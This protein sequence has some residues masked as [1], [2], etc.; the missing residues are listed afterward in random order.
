[1]NVVD[2]KTKDII[3]EDYHKVKGYNLIL[4]DIDDL[5]ITIK[6]ISQNRTDTYC[7]LEVNFKDN[8][9]INEYS[10]KYACRDK[11]DEVILKDLKEIIFDNTIVLA[12]SVWVTL[13]EIVYDCISKCESRYG[14][15]VKD[16]TQ[17]NCD[18]FIEM[19]SE[20]FK[21]DKIITIYVEHEDKNNIQGLLENK[22]FK[23]V[24]KYDKGNKVSLLLGE[25]EDKISKATKVIDSLVS[26][27][28]S[29]ISARFTKGECMLTIE[30]PNDL[31]E[32]W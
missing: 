4:K 21:E 9:Y 11:L 3:S 5:Y 28:D 7:K 18:A 30:A 20:T 26:Y 16:Y 23:L 1:M 17:H 27:T 24:K 31:N 15:P 2:I 25:N 13:D 14:K 6:F 32:D 10:M 8:K 12:G 22:E 29:T 19:Y